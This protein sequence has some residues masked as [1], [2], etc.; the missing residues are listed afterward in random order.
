MNW[1][2]GG[3]WQA[4]QA[5]REQPSL[6]LRLGL[7]AEQIGG[8]FGLNLGFM[9]VDYAFS[10]MESMLSD[11]F[12]GHRLSLSFRFGSG[13]DADSVKPRAAAMPRREAPAAN[14]PFDYYQRAG[15]IR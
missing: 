11:S 15:S 12:G 13:R 1:A 14:D 7:N 10:L 4:L 5:T 8:G 6:V 9:R 3:E 2:L